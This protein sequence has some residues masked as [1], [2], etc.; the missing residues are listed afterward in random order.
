MEPTH[1]VILGFALS[2]IALSFL[3]GCA[4]SRQLTIDLSSGEALNPNSFS[5]SDSS[6]VVP[7]YVVRVATPDG[8]GS[9]DKK[10]E[11]T[12][13][14]S[15]VRRVTVEVQDDPLGWRLI[16]GLVIGC[17]GAGL[18]IAI[19]GQPGAFLGGYVGAIEGG[20]IGLGLGLLTGP[21]IADGLNIRYVQE[22]I[23][24]D[25]NIPAQRDSLRLYSGE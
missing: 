17:A 10:I 15:Q 6:I 24:L 9:Y 11:R 21:S 14:F 2:C 12:L 1:R 5:M 23:E 20:A 18:G 25:P 16:G 13:P 4:P 19:G 8:Y 3:G 22:M 7:P